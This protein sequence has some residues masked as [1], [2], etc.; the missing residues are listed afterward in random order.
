MENFFYSI[1][2]VIFY[3]FNHTIS[4]PFLDKFF[5]II[6]NVN[7]WYVAYVILLLICYFKGG[8]KGK[9][10]VVGVI[11][12]ITFSDQVAYHILKESFHRLRPCMALKDAITPLGCNGTYSFPSNHAVNN[13]AA[14]TFFYFLFPK[15][16]WPLFIT[17]A[18]IAI[19][20]VYLGLHYP[21]DI[22][23]GAIIGAFFG[24]LF[25]LGTIKVVNIIEKKHA[26]VKTGKITI[27]FAIENDVQ[28]ILGLIKELAEYEKLSDQ[29]KVTENSLRESLFINKFP[30]V[31]IAEYENKAVG[32]AIFFHNYST[33]LSQLGIYL[34]DI[35]VKKEYRNQGIG[36]SIF[37]E[38]V[39]VAAERNCGR[40]EWAVLD[41]N[42]PSINFYKKI[43]AVPIKDWIIFR[44]KSDKFN[45]FLV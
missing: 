40:I 4:T 30:E 8:I 44:L 9:I 6:T 21:S 38:L 28:T 34:E 19:S 33:F 12:L 35:Y 32:Y 27:R 20:R 24:Y 11:L 17:A 45:K 37:Q 36:K 23:G 10:A 14:A 5:S 26:V 16:K 25:Y 18:L 15:Y 3:F 29:L 22:L 13:F 31:F 2:L 43:G 1:D 41:W 39:K 7:N 42:E